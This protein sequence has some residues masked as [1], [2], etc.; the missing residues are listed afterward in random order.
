M[1]NC[2]KSFSYKMN[3]SANQ[4]SNA[5]RM[6][7]L[8]NTKPD[9]PKIAGNF[10][11]NKFTASWSTSFIKLIKGTFGGPDNQSPDFDGT[12]E[13]SANGSVLTLKM[14]SLKYLLLPIPFMIFVLFLAGLSIYDYFCNENLASLIFSIVPILLFA[15]VWILI[16][17]KLN[18]QYKKMKNFIEEFFKDNI[19]MQ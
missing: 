1:F 18:R 12:V 19:I 13:N 9:T 17:T 6:K 10:F 14:K 15:G 8:G 16:F 3:I 5:L 7:A 2:I 11:A 4:V